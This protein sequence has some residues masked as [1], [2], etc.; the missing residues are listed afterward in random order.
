[1]ET[2]N[3]LERLHAE[4]LAAMET[5]GGPTSSEWLQISTRL[6]EIE[7]EVF[8]P[9]TGDELQL[10]IESLPAGAVD[11]EAD[12]LQLVDSDGE[13]SRP[14]ADGSPWAGG[15]H[16]ARGDGAGRPR[17]GRFL[18]TL[19]EMAERRR[20]V[21]PRPARNDGAAADE[22]LVTERRRRINSALRSAWQ[23]TRGE[24]PPVS[25]PKVLVLADDDDNGQTTAPDTNSGDSPP[26]G[27]SGS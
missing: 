13:V 19:A 22:E 1:M 23:D 16:R 18:K 21:A 2:D 5:E 7:T 27:G 8:D 10:L 6:S 24:A 11:I 4:L 14:D 17:I 25:N 3:R 12:L 26:K 9:S 20:A 15:R